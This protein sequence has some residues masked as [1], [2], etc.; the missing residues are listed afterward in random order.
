MVTLRSAAA[1]VLE[2][3]FDGIYA[4]T[5]VAGYLLAT[6]PV[7]QH[8]PTSRRIMRWIRYGL[9]ATE[10]RTAPGRDLVVNF[11]DLVTCQA[12]T[13]LRE[14][15]FGLAD[16][17]TTEHYFGREYGVPK[18][19]AHRRF[20]YSGRDI[21]GR[22]DR[23]LVSGTKGGHIAWDFLDEW[24]TPPRVELGFSEETH[25]AAWWRPTLGVLLKPNVQFGQPCVEGT[26]IR[27]SSI[28][29]YVNAGD[30]PAYLAEAY[31]VEVAAIE[32]AVAWEERVRSALDS[33]AALPA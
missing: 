22:I 19:F 17:L 27:T 28:W 32:R 30:S 8:P 29:G 25:R 10:R 15:G 20:W 9:V 2:Y 18:P 24:L 11:E 5:E 12:I 4:P 14:A 1:R 3:Q 6:M 33:T 31:Q 7:E 13:L 26:R 23:W 21:F 16:I